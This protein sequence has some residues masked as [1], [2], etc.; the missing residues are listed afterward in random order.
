[1]REG[2]RRPKSSPNE[3]GVPGSQCRMDL[4]FEKYRDQVNEYPRFN[5][6]LELTLNAVKLSRCY[7]C[8]NMRLAGSILTPRMREGFRRPKLSP[9]ELSVPG[10]QSRMELK[11][12][13][14]R[15]QVNEYPRFDSILELTTFTTLNAVELDRCHSCRSTSPVPHATLAVIPR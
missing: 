8:R 3:L 1:M 2:C 14:Y 4:K 7:S 10:C 12:E 9:N 13:K 6:T 11:F 5:S 15:D